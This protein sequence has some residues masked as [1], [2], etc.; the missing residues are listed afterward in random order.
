MTR[1]DAPD[2]GFT[3]VAVLFMILLVM[4]LSVYL[5]L[6]LANESTTTSSLDSELYSL[7]L[8]EDGVEYAR[9]LL[10][11]L[12]LNQLLA[13]LD[14]KHS[15]TSTPQWRNPL[16]FELARGI[17]PDTWSPTCDDGWPASNGSLLLP[18]GYAAAG[19]GRFYIRFSNNPTESA[20]EDRDG[21]VLIRSMGVT[22][23]NRSGLFH[24]SRNNVSLVEASFRQERVFDLPA[25]LV[26][27]GEGANFEWPS[28][29]FE[30]DGTVNPAVEA[31]GSS[32]MIDSFLT[33]L[34]PG[35][36]ACFPGAGGTPSVR[37][38]TAS[39]MAS[40]IYRR[41]FDTRFW[42]HFQEQLPAFTDP[43]QPGLCFY[44]NG[45]GITGSF[46]GFLVARGDF[47]A[48]GASI[49]GLVLHL[50]GGRLTLGADTHIRGAIWMSN[51]DS[52]AEG[53]MVHQPLDL[54]VL[55]SVTVVYDAG[56]VRRSLT[57]LPPTQLGWRI[58]F[59][60][61]KL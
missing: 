23:A 11:H 21:V 41:V 45:G 29:G 20:D 44:A 10:P 7:I 24:S 58:L 36:G 37:D 30:F 54:K 38:S 57:L 27:F 16:S 14:G 50:G 46:Q 43:H 42:Q 53:N 60:E 17:A 35:Q 52:D 48:S 1:K 3:L 26:L 18:S 55:G 22:A 51:T 28:E 40:P 2:C 33:S 39:Y 12:E 61:M 56:A 32:Q 25:A 4:A 59:P 6:L 8:A 47:V 34:A 9:S 15:G 19:G 5:C 13:G 49:D 31:V